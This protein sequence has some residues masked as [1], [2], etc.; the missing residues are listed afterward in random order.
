M[1]NNYLGRE[2][3]PIE[4]ETWKVLDSTMA[5]AAKSVLAGR[6][7]LH[8]EGPYGLGLKAVPLQ[9]CR[10]EGGLIASCFLPVNM[11]FNTFLM[12][13]RDIAASE[14]EGLPID[15][16][17]VASAAIDVATQE[18]SLIF[19]GAAGVQ[20]LMN[21]E[22]TGKY[23]MASWETIGKAADDVIAAINLLDKAGF[24]GPYTMALAPSRYNLL[25][26]RYP[27]GGTEL[28]HVQ[29]IETDGVV[30]SP[31]LETGGVQMAS[32]RQYA[33][34]VLGQDMT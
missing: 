13:E 12:S 30:K 2:D 9:D 10:T 7:L 28:E 26:R 20:G 32:G 1:E 17:V 33:A 23:K 29:S 8:T 5:E 4:S 6:R 14:R 24:H 34:I 15:T 25:F 27:Q 19:N 31:V 3:A 22:G 21:T 11:I 18:D 16:S